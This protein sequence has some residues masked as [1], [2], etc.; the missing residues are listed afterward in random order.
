LNGT[1]I[2]DV[3]V[4]GTGQAGLA[5]GW[6]LRGTGLSFRLQERHPRIGDSWRERYDSLALFSSRAYSALPGLALPGDPNGYPG[7][8]EIAVYLGTQ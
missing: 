5:T 1:D 2:V 7:K 8:D 6:L 3:L 4:I